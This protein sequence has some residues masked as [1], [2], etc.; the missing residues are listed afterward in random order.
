MYDQDGSQPDTRSRMQNTENNSLSPQHYR[1]RHGFKGEPQGSVYI[2]A[3]FA[4]HDDLKSHSGTTVTFGTGAYYTKST[5]K[6]LNT[7]SSSEAELFALSK[8]MQQALWSLAILSAL[9]FLV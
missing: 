1:F 7:S 5:T 9:G 3:S 4:K 2:D 6:K 8:G